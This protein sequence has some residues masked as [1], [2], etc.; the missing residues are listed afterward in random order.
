[1]D[2]QSYMQTFMQREAPIVT[3]EKTLENSNFKQWG[4]KRWI[5]QPYC[6]D[7]LQISSLAESERLIDL[8]VIV[9][10]TLFWEHWYYICIPDLALSLIVC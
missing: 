6:D 4:Y 7:M 10:V 8:F 3:I 1:M 9:Q 2:Y 5:F